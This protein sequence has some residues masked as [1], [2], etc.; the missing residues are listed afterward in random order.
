[1]D[2]VIKESYPVQGETGEIYGELYYPVTRD[3]KGTVILSH[4]YNGCH[5]DFDYECR[6]F[7]ENGYMAY[8]YDFSGGS[9]NT[10]SVSITHNEMTV[11]TEKSDLLCVF[12]GVS[13]HD[14]A[15]GKSIYLFGGSQ[16]GFVTGLVL[17]ELKDKVRASMLYYPAFNIPDDWRR[18]YPKEEEIPDITELMGMTLGRCYFE[19]IRDFY[20]FDNLGSYKGPLLIIYGDKDDIVPMSAIQ[21]AMDTYENAEL[22][23]LKGEGHGFTT[24]GCKKAMERIIR[25]LSELEK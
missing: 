8:A 3:I 2:T 14:L 25:Y 23:I 13:S 11:F 24:E 1:M 7:A 16:G 21:Q 17:E 19:A 15:K 9:V 12:E 22:I 10:R 5:N 18:N 6:V 20:T 4:G